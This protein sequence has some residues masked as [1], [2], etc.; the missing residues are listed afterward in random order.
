MIKNEAVKNGVFQMGEKNTAYAEV[1][2]GQS[3][4]Q[5]LVSDPAIQVSVG[6]VTFEPSCRNNWH[7][8][9][10]GFQVLLVTSGEGWY[11]EAG[12]AARHLKVGD[13]VTIHDGVKHWH[14]ATSNSWFSHV[15]ITAGSSEW[16]EAVSDETYNQL[17]GVK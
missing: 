4:L 9:H 5:M 10:D 15:A 7:I 6:N 13:V 17:E 14:G 11:Q 16:L 2:K 12:S 3:Y 1:F 8:H